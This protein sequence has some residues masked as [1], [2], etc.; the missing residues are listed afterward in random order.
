MAKN[1]PKHYSYHSRVKRKLAVTVFFTLFSIVLC[2]F[3]WAQALNTTVLNYEE[4]SDVSYMVHLKENDYYETDTLGPGKQ[5]I[6]SLIDYIN[7]TFVHNFTINK[8][9]DFKYT[10]WIEAEILVEEPGDI[11]NL[12]FRRNIILTEPNKVERNKAKGFTI[13]QSVKVDYSE[14]NQLIK[15]FSMDYNLTANSRLLVKLHI[16]TEAKYEN[17]QNPIETDRIVELNI[18]LTERTVNVSLNANEVHESGN[19]FEEPSENIINII[20]LGIAIMATIVGIIKIIGTIRFLIKTRP[21]VDKYQKR[22]KKILREYDRIIVETKT[23]INITDDMEVFEIDNFD[24]LL[25]V[26]DRLELPILYMEIHKEKCW[27]IVR[28]G[29]QIYRKVMKAADFQ[30]EAKS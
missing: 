18:P 15:D 5:Y 13:N 30:E 29:N 8:E 23:L 14:Y 1:T 16:E 4:N 11:N 10:Y 17:F 19:Y 21:K 20:T 24:E 9:V 28:D 12:I 22:L 7:V 6:A 25:D 2:V 27:F 3:L 26:S